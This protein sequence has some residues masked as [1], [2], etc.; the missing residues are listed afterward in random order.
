MFYCKLPSA[1]I[2]KTDIEK[3]LRLGMEA[4][5]ALALGENPSTAEIA[6][7]A[8][9]RKTFSKGFERYTEVLRGLSADSEPTLEQLNSLIDADRHARMAVY[10]PDT[11]QRDQFLNIYGRSRMVLIFWHQRHWEDFNEHWGEFV[12]ENT[13][14]LQVKN[15]C[16]FENPVDVDGLKTSLEL[17]TTQ[18]INK[19]RELLAQDSLPSSQTAITN[20]ISATT[21]N[22]ATRP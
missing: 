20:R 3:R 21:P 13:N 17:C 22:P 10:N 1:D 8:E 2:I 4:F 19:Y 7:L 5:N 9:V 12:E 15:R 11:G 16:L 14:H 18:T 6:W